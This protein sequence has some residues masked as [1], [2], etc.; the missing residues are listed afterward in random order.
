MK[1]TILGGD[2]KEIPNC[3]ITIPR[4]GKI[5]MKILPDISDGKSASYNDEAVI[6]RSYPMKTY[7]HSENRSINWTAYFMVCKQSDIYTNLNYLRYIESAVYP[8][9][10]FLP[11]APPPVCQIACGD[12]LVPL[13][14]G[15]KELCVVLKSYSVKFPTDVPW[16]EETNL[17]YRFSVDMNW[18]VVYNSNDLPGQEDILTLGW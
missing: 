6:G 2:L 10:N 11:Y 13:A 8:K 12:L 1:S 14:N 15:E 9:Q 17:P 4:G 18:E 7:S 16:D 5:P 3:Y